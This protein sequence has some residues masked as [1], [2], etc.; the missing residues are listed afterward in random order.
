M[1][2]RKSEPA[3]S[4]VDARISVDAPM[5][6]PP[7]SSTERAANERRR[8]TEAFDS[9][10][11]IWS[12]NLRLMRAGAALL[13]AFEDIYFIIDSD[14]PPALTPA[15]VA[16]HAGAVGITALVLAHDVELVRAQLAGSMPCEPARHLWPDLGVRPAHRRHRAALHHRGA[17]AY[18]RR[19]AIAVVGW[20]AGV[21]KRDR[22]G[23][24]GDTVVGAYTG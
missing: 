10:T 3:D 24:Y 14:F 19:G 15:A 16:L 23:D 2:V 17:N 12:F 11:R 1:A 5:P 4:I 21:V 18:R 20:L 22:V 7:A 9:D 13:V 8:A 6:V